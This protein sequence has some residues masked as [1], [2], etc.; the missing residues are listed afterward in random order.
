MDFCDTDTSALFD[1]HCHCGLVM[2]ES[3]P[4][5]PGEC[6]LIAT[7]EVRHWK[8]LASLLAPHRMRFGCAG[9]HP[10]YAHQWDD[11]CAAQLEEVLTLPG[12]VAVGEVGLDPS[13]A[14][15]I[16]LQKQVLR[17][18]IRMALKINK[19]LVLHVSRGYVEILEVLEEEN[20]QRVGGV[21]HGFSAGENI[22]R[23]FIRLGF[24]LG[25][26]PV[27]LRRNARKLPEALRSLPLERLVI[28]TDAQA[29]MKGYA[30]AAQGSAILARIAQHLAE[31]YTLSYAQIVS[32]LWRNSCELFHLELP[33][34]DY[35]LR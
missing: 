9:L 18:Q 31:V 16:S 7:A 25:I 29:E 17:Q 2:D 32:I 3:A 6:E 12:V 28:E 5:Q 19:P 30:T 35:G 26:G 10:W 22:G 8:E 11:A 23:E 27:L 14:V 20:A 4:A 1:T 33:S 13:A 21:V 34:T 24:Y 15:H